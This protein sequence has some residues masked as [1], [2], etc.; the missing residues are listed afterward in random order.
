LEWHYKLCVKIIYKHFENSILPYTHK[1]S[2]KTK[3]LKTATMDMNLIYITFILLIINIILLDVGGYIGL[4]YK[5][6]KVDKTTFK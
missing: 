1:Y 2:Q 3:Q 5:V 6:G 4:K